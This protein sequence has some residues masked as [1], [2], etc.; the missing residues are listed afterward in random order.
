MRHRGLPIASTTLVA[1]MLRQ[2]VTD[3]HNFAAA[4]D[5]ALVRFA[6]G[7]RKDDVRGAVSVD[8]DHHRDGQPLL[9]LRRR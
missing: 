8:R 9:L 2:F 3:I 1:P 4:H 5:V 6:K 7:Q